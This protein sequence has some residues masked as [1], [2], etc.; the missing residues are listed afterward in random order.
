[1]KHRRRIDADTPLAKCPERNI[2]LYMPIPLSNRVD[3]LVDL[4]EATAE[5]TTRKELIAALLYAAP[6]DAKELSEIVK[7]Y[8]V[9]SAR[10]ALI[11]VPPD[12]RTVTLS[13]ARPGP[14]KR[15][16]T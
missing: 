1:M 8:R 7:A 6:T 13:T 9:A 4:V 5:R 12:A 15:Q 10:D 2:G 14:R 16:K 3:D 11:H